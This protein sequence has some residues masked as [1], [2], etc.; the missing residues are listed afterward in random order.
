MSSM[1][2]PAGLFAL[3]L[4][5]LAANNVQMLAYHGTASPL[6]NPER[7]FRAELAD[8]PAMAQLG[9]C[10]K[11]NLTLTQAYCYLTPFCR[12]SPCAPLSAS[13]L[14]EV[15]GGFARARRAGVKLVL[16][17]AYENSSEHPMDGPSSYDEIFG[18][19]RQLQPLVHAN[20]DVIH[21][22]AAGFVGAYGEWHSSAHQ[23][24]ANETGLAA[25][26]A[27]E[28]EWFVPADRSV[29]IRAPRQ[30]A[31]LLRTWAARLPS[32]R[33]RDALHWCIAGPGP[34]RNKTEPCFRLGY[35]NDGF[36][37]GGTDGGT[38][39][40]PA[41]PYGTTD[42]AT[43]VTL[44][45]N[46]PG[47][48]EFDYMT[49]EA[50]Y[51]LTDGEPY[52]H[53]KGC[54]PRPPGQGSA[55]LNP[56]CARPRSAGEISH[57]AGGATAVRLRNHHYT[58]FSFARNCEYLLA[59]GKACAEAAEAVDFWRSSRLDAGLV[60][61]WKLPHAAE[62][63]V[64]N[65]THL[66]YLTDHIGYRLELT[67]AR[68]P[69]AVAAGGAFGFDASV[70]NRGFAAPMNPRPVLAV[71]LNQSARVPVPI[72]LGAIDVD[73]R[74]LQPYLPNDPYFYPLTHRV[75]LPPVALPPSVVAG[76]WSLGLYLPDARADLH[77]DDARFAIRLANRDVQWWS[78][79]G[80][81]GVNV[82]ATVTV[83][84]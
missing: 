43:G 9:V 36:G 72:V 64:D 7:G 67:T 19:M 66:Q 34:D 16:R 31:S 80:R 12:T 33:Q 54:R 76:T 3:L 48:P 45:F 57:E 25:L 21:A 13:F 1:L 46:L 44:P 62:Y 26:V 77:D 42:N 35:D 55:G 71:L 40:S 30:K 24:E 39:A 52:A 22:M 18:H 68:V 73:V 28:L 4:P 27:A 17:F 70:V 82:I 81:Y 78:A 60:D 84:Q 23:L 20:A 14:D 75:S 11:F 53:N 29:I 61:E 10:A 50:P 41:R 59:T 2:R 83:T 49:A 37:A 74:D 32:Q 65:V 6:V 15:Q 56:M 69:S 63:A 51:V 47:N 58:S 38:W 5:A 8:F 79:G